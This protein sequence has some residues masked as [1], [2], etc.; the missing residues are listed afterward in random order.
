MN[1]KRR[2]STS[3]EARRIRQ[4][5]HDIAKLFALKLGLSD[6]YQNDLKAKKDVI[7]PS[8]D[9][10]SVKAGTKKWQIF[11]YSLS[12]FEEFKAMNGIGDILISCI[13]SFPSTYEEYQQNKVVYKNA[14]APKMELLADKLSK[15]VVLAAFLEK[16]IF[17][18]GEVNYLTVYH[19]GKFHVFWGK[20]V[21]KVMVSN[22]TVTNSI[23][24]NATQFSSQKVILR[25]ENQNLGEI[26]M[27]ND[28]QVHYREIRFNMIKPKAMALL[29]RT[30]TDCSEFQEDVLVYGEAKKHFGR[31]KH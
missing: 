30:I 11:L 16:S 9:A 18:G 3:D 19:D 26:E 28:S 20:E 8:G 10:H 24:R 29:F 4:E 2:G 13:D 7:D 17:N 5:G 31:W 21:V 23:A 15:P 12:R 6:D 14:L 22:L 25:F 27:R 1:T